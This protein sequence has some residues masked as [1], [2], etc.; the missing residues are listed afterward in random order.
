MWSDI[1]S[2]NTKGNKIRKKSET[3]LE[4]EAI[5]EEK[6]SIL[7]VLLVVVVCAIAGIGIATILYDLAMNS[8]AVIGR[9][10]LDLL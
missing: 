7:G 2:K 5:M 9:N 1:V 3:Q 4:Q 8:G 6:I 10:L